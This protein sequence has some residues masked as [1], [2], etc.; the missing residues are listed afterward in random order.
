M[1]N[2]NISSRY[3][4]SMV[5]F[6]LLTA[7]IGWRSSLGHPENFNG[8]CVSTSLLHRRRSTEV[9]QILHD[10]FWCLLDWYTMYTFL[11]LL[12]GTKFNL[13]PSL[14]FSY[15]AVLLH[16]TRAV[17]VSQTLRRCTGMELR[18][19]RP[20]STEGTTYIPRAAITQ[21]EREWTRPRI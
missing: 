19:F 21:S 14:V 20:W 5:K 12:P 1:L 9:N 8:F 13:R 16:G 11:K 7:E 3:P 2:S 10:V 15:M 6:G 17:G 4:H 18:N